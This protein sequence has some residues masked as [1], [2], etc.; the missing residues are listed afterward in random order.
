MDN[1]HITKWL[2]HIRVLSDEIGPRGSTTEAERRGSDYCEKALAGEGFTP[3]QETF[4]SARSIYSPHL[5]TSAAILVSF[6]LYPISSRITAAAAFIIT[7]VF[8]VS[9]LLELSLRDNLLR[10][11]LPKGTS[12]NVIAQLP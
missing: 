6:I 3:M 4:P 2:E 9:E 5:F 8:L 7:V 11:L 12:Q 1:A 10:R